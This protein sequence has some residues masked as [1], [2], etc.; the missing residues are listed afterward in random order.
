MFELD[1]YAR[2]RLAHRDG[3]SVREIARRFS[4]SRQAV[5]KALAYAEPPGYRRTKERTAPRLDRVK[6][7]ID[8]ILKDDESAPPKQ[9]HTAMQIHRR[10]V[11]E[12]DYAGG[13]DQVRR[14]VQKQRRDR[15]ETFV[16]LT[17]EAG[18]RVEC[19]FGKIYVDFPEGRRQVSV[20]LVTW[21]HSHYCFAI[22]LP[23]EKVEAILEGTVRAFEFFECVP[24]EV[25]WDN[26]TTVASEILTGRQRR[27]QQRYQA[28]ASH[29]N[30]EPQFCMPARGN[31]KPDVENRV[32]RLQ[33]TWATPVPQVQDLDELNAYLRRCC[34]QELERTV[35]RTE[36]SIGARFAEDRAGAVSLPRH[37]FDPCI[38]RPADVDKYQTVR[39][40]TNWY[41]VPRQFAFRSVTVKAY[42]NHIEIVDGDQVIARHPRSYERHY[43]ELDPLHYLAILPRKPA[44]LDHADVYRHWSLPPVFAQLRDRFEAKHGANTGARHYIRVLQLLAEHSA[45]RVAQAIEHCLARGHL[46]ARLIAE[47]TQRLQAASESSS[48]TT[49]TDVSQLPEAA[50]SARVAPTGLGHFDRLLSQG[51]EEPHERQTTVT[52]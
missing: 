7:I 39:H 4:R 25:W 21:A 14:Y 34:A 41:S 49:P 23:S 28:L 37:R 10:L 12:H 15:R 30:F 11:A 20:L 52:A 38:R 50:R 8:Q 36:Q 27:L 5:R 48:E 26:P 16:P 44:V 46:D 17:H 35:Q 43:K 29:Y 42:I 1:E 45:Q 24:R 47:Q 51:G 6:P 3:M 18:Q 31:E 33:R 2:I 13:Y 40:E 19:D 9:R 22:A 32:K